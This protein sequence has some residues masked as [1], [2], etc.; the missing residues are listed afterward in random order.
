M[1]IIKPLLT[2]AGRLGQYL[3]GLQD[4]LPSGATALAAELNGLFAGAAIVLAHP[5]I[6]VGSISVLHTPELF[7]NRGVGSRLL[8]EAERRLAEAGCRSCRATLTLRSG[9]PSPE[10]E[11]L[12]KRGYDAE[13]LLQRNYVI[14]SARLAQAAWLMRLKLPPDARL[15]LLLSATEE[16][17]R[18][19]DR[20][21]A[22]LPPELHPF[23]EERVLDAE[24]SVMLKIEG[25]VAGWLGVQ[26]LG[27]TLLAIHA[28][29]VDP[30]VRLFGGAFALFAE[31]DRKLKLTSQFAYLMFSISG[32]DTSTLRVCARKLEPHASSVKSLVRL[33]KKL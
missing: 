8:Q 22:V 3:P 13:T 5:R 27:S 14:R 10:Y 7:R 15:D 16:E 19:I 18:E 21:A 11:F 17:R 28:V 2:E 29:H 1:I 25:R 30:N 6:P 4:P 9:V 20:L 31:T 26:K 24:L 32:Q 33:E 23:D 12:S